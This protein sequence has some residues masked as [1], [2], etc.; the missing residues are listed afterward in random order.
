MIG[1]QQSSTVGQACFNVG[2]VKS[3]YGTGCFMMLNSGDEIVHSTNKLL[4]TICYAINNKITYALEGSIFYAGAA[5]SWLR[6][7]LQLIHS[8]DEIENVVK[9]CSDE[10]IYMVPALAGLGA[11]YW[12]PEVRGIITG[13]SNKTK[14][15][16]IIKA[17]LESVAY[18]TYD[19]VRAME[20]D[21]VNIKELRID[22]GMV[23][24][25]W[26]TEF[27]AN[28]TNLKI[29][30]SAN[31]EATAMGAAYLAGLQYGI[32]KDLEEIATLRQEKIILESQISARKHNELVS[33]WQKAI[34]MLVS[35]D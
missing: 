32:F 29:N 17:T 6:D 27:L 23:K 5:I 26:F 25:R 19:L 15:E 22:G 12:K 33:G 28:I 30:V 31:S 18:Q 1:D 16:H 2:M 10:N 3:T 4:T 35:N 20:Q 13:L 11:P 34:N 21:G 14:K 24:N 7:N 9:N 8:T